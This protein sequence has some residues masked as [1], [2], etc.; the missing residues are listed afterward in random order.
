ML[1]GKAPFIGG[2]SL[3]DLLLIGVKLALLASG[4]C[5]GLVQDGDGDGAAGIARGRDVVS[6]NP[7]LGDQAIE[8][9]TAALYRRAQRLFAKFVALRQVVE[10][11]V[12]FHLLFG[13][14]ARSPRRSDGRRFVES[15]V[16]EVG[17][18]I[19]ARE[20]DFGAER[21]HGSQDFAERRDVV[22]GNPFAEFEQCRVENRGSVER[23]NDGLDLDG[24]F[25]VVKFSDDASESLFAKGNEYASPNDGREFA[26]AVG[27]D[28]VERHGQRD[29]AVGGHEK[30]LISLEEGVVET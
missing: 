22:G 11:G 9:A 28:R 18:S 7:L 15:L 25:A 1:D 17:D 2:E 29:V 23:L 6:R 19:Y 27:E 26:S 20:A 16:A 12:L 10:D 14:H 13:R 3:E 21:Q 8:R 30:E 4:T 24:L 5:G